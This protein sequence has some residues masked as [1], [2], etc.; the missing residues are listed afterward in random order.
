MPA[1]REPTSITNAF[2]MVTPPPA[3]A[4]VTVIENPC[5]DVSI[6]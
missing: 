5:G 1:A 3:I 2:D 4:G 6:G